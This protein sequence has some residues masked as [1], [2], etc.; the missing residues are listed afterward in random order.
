M[1][2]NLAKIIFIS[3][4]V[5]SIGLFISSCGKE[6]IFSGENV[7]LSFS[8][9]TL[10]FDT[11]FTTQ[12][13]ATRFVK[14]F[15]QEDET[16]ILDKIYMQDGANSF[17]R[18]N[19]DGTPTEEA[20]QIEIKANDSIYVFVEVT[21]DPD[22]PI[23]ASPFVIE[24]YLTIE[25]RDQQESLLFEAW[26]QNANYITGRD[27]AGDVNPRLLSCNLGQVIF[28][29]PK[30]YIIHGQLIIDSCEIVIPEGTQIYVHGGFIFNEGSVFNDGIIVCLKNGRIISQGTAE[31]PVV[32]QGDRLEEDFQDTPGQWVGIRFFNESRGNVLNHTI[33]KNS[34]IGLRADSLAQVSIS[35]SRFL[36]TSSAGI[37]GVHAE[38]SMDNCEFYNNATNGVQLGYG[39]KYAMNH[40]TIYNPSNQ[41]PGLV[42]TNF[43]CQDVDCLLPLLINPLELSLQNNIIS[44]TNDDEI[45]FIDAT[46][47][48][49]ELFWQVSLS[50]SLL[51]VKDILE[52]ELY[53]DLFTSCNTCI[54]ASDTDSL[55]L[56]RDAFDLRLDT[57]SRAIDKGILSPI[58]TDILGQTR[59]N[60][61]DLGAYEFIP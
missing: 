58:I 10:R 4:M 37:I 49:E 11:V 8:V 53:K 39:G 48:T 33:I 1:L 30:P 19:V 56:D 38:I 14:V 16:I 21:I 12:G 3:V 9:D 17:F 57:M 23:S 26:G 41:D 24:D 27:A 60:L 25:Y 36:N 32:F 50:H 15:N 29:D 34:I 22:L 31:N 52:E 59:D 44:G 46:D 7:D 40:C 47:G 18:L 51:R 42:A 54:V 35:N 55:F 13:S 20:E 6:S 45:L 28:D 61:P 5:I 2:K 43:A